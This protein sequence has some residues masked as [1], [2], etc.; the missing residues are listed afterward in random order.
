MLGVAQPTFWAEGAGHGVIRCTLWRFQ[1]VF[2]CFADESAPGIGSASFFLLGGTLLKTDFKGGH[3]G[4]H[5][6]NIQL[7]NA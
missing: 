1:S 2:W 4:A 7:D 5:M 6:S 3:N